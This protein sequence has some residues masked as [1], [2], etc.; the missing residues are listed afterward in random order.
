MTYTLPRFLAAE[1]PAR[2]E[3]PRRG[4][5]RILRARNNNEMANNSAIR[6]DTTKMRFRMRKVNG[7]TCN[8][9]FKRE[10]TLNG[11]KQIRYDTR[12]TESGSQLT[13]HGMPRF[14]SDTRMCIINSHEY[15]RHETLRARARNYTQRLHAI[16]SNFISRVAPRVSRLS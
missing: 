3:I 5:A 4:A 11:V 1:N 15:N 8:F 16:F 12:G 9:R 2:L 7:K 14:R 6:W 13:R 10:T